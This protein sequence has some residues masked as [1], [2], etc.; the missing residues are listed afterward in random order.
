M[1][2]T[3]NKNKSC[4]SHRRTI[5]G[6]R[7]EPNTRR[8]SKEWHGFKDEYNKTLNSYQRQISIQ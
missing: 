7:Y 8:V 1:G 3:R 4:Q 2:S 5:V 6:L